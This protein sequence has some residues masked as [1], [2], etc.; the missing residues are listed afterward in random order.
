[1]I[2]ELK[3][4]DI[5][6]AQDSILNRF[7]DRS[8]RYIGETLDQLL[9]DSSYIQNIPNI[10]VVE[11]NGKLFSMDNRRLWVYKKAEELGSLETIDVIRTSSFNRNKFTTKNGGTSIRVRG[12]PGGIIWKTRSPVHIRDTHDH[13]D[14]NKS[15]LR[16]QGP[17]GSTN[18]RYKTNTMVTSG[19][20]GGNEDDTRNVFHTS[21][22]YRTTKPLFEDIDDRN[23]TLRSPDPDS[24]VH[25]SLKSRSNSKCVYEAMDKTPS[26]AW[27]NPRKVMENEISES[28]SPVITR[29]SKFSRKVM[30]NEI[31][32]SSSPVFT[33]TST[34][35]RKVMDNEIS[36][37]SSPVITRTS[38]FSRKAMVK[39]T[40]GS[41]SPVTDARSR[42]LNF[43][44]GSRGDRGG[45]IQKTWSPVSTRDTYNYNL[46]KSSI[47]VQGPPV[48]TISRS[49]VLNSDY[50]SSSTRNQ[51]KLDMFQ[52]MQRAKT[53]FINTDKNEYGTSLQRASTR[54]HSNQT[55]ERNI[56][57]FERD[58]S[59]DVRLNS[60]NVRRNTISEKSELN[61][62][63]SEFQIMESRPK[64][65]YKPMPTSSIKCESID[66]LEAHTGCDCND[67]R[68]RVKNMNGI[69][70][71]CALWIISMKTCWS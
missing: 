9:E 47:R 25:G 29:T 13:D 23:I 3:P 37:S 70:E 4:S 27:E 40:S 71:K 24:Y 12:D 63:F 30:D 18:S 20:N 56:N 8:I 44:S 28:S 51:L 17:P 49:R 36:E 22:R 38:K 16:V 54:R 31:S 66:S 14:L 39:E 11:I 7:R 43:D 69:Y 58:T 64:Y 19:N 48:S 5:L 26:Y 33:R 60:N 53:C 46:N 62:K 55:H 68:K 57:V 2:L 65:E 67:R 52:K 61:D 21:S 32:E 1:M 15:S 41:F 6:Y 59:E 35:S 42:D 50:G 45:E 10:E 34:V